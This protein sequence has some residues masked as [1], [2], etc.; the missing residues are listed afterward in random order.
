MH[1]ESVCAFA[2]RGVDL[3][4]RGGDVK[5]REGSEEAEAGGTAA[6][7]VCGE[8]IDAA[9]ERRAVVGGC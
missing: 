7:E 3:L 8:G 1:A 9:G 4:E 5:H 2:E 6:F